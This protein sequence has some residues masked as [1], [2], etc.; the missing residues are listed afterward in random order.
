MPVDLNEANL[1]G[2]MDVLYAKQT[3]EV[4][5]VYMLIAPE[6]Y[7]EMCRV[8]WPWKGLRAVWLKRKRNARR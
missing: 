7:K 8:A 4:N 2:L 6:L 1:S 3:G 5:P